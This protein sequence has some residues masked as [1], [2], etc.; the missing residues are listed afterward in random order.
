MAQIKNFTF[1]MGGDK[2]LWYIHSDQ[3]PGNMRSLMFFQGLI[4]QTVI[5]YSL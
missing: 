3:K 1:Y 2:Y 5:I 4:C